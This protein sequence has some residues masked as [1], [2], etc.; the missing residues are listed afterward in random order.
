MAEGEQAHMPAP[1][2]TRSYFDS[3]MNIAEAARAREGPE[4]NCVSW[5]CGD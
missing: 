1:R 2:M 5:D 3:V 4:T